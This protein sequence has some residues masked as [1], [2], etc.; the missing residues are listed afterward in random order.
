MKIRPGWDSGKLADG[1][2]RFTAPIFSKIPSYSNSGRLPS[3]IP[4]RALSSPGTAPSASSASRAHADRQSGTTL[5]SSAAARSGAPSSS[6]SHNPPSSSSRRGHRS[7]GSVSSTGDY[8]DDDYSTGE[9]SESW[10]DTADIAEQ[11][12]EDG[13][14]A[15]AVRARLFDNIDRDTL[16]GALKQRQ[17]PSSAADGS[18]SKAHRNK[19]HVHYDDGLTSDSD[20]SAS[21]RQSHHFHHGQRGVVDKEAIHIPESVVHRVS[22]VERFL[23]ATMSGGSS[24]HGLTGKPLIYFTSIFVSLGVFLFG[25]DQGVMSGIIT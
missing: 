23:A 11:L 9:D 20:N 21:P 14:N 24:I 10:L 13:D 3:N 18:S 6:R 5:L 16:A 22:T 15:P 2:C 17:H 25:Y 12:A 19:K 1:R 8:S 7:Q 4:L